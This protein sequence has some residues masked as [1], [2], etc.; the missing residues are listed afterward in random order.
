MGIGTCLGGTAVHTFSPPSTRPA[1]PTDCG[2]DRCRNYRSV[3]GCR[4]SGTECPGIFD[5]PAP[6]PSRVSFFQTGK[7]AMSTMRNDARF[8]SHHS[9]SDVADESL[10]SDSGSCCDNGCPSVVRHC[11]THGP[12]VT[13]PVS[14]FNAGWML[15]AQCHISLADAIGRSVTGTV[16]PVADVGGAEW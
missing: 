16:F 4:L 5:P 1:A 2:Y 6:G 15:F 12:V 11:R 13:E 3:H 9:R 7:L 10:W 8:C 14:N